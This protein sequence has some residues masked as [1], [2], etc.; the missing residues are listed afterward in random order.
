[1]GKST[2]IGASV[3]AVTMLMAVSA[4]AGKPAPVTSCGSVSGAFV[5]VCQTNNDLDGRTFGIDPEYI[6]SCAPGERG[7]CY[8]SVAQKLGS[9][10]Q[11][12]PIKKDDAW[13]AVCTIL[14]D[15]YT[16]TYDSKKP[17]L[18]EGGYTDLKSAVQELALYVDDTPCPT[19][20]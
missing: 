5:Q 16:W 11:K 13:Q 7:N 12:F 14:D 8:E 10:W 9:A 18:T 19:K 6:G 17:K 3:L 1:M 15:A 4:Q 20:D 2:L